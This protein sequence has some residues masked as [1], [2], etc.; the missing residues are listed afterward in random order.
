MNT[1]LRFAILSG[2]ALILLALTASPSLRPVKAQNHAHDPTW[3]SKYEFI[4][5][6]SEV[7]HEKR[8]EDRAPNKIVVNRKGYR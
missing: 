3:W 4:L 5:N 7:S 2:V 6:E 1:R 8:D